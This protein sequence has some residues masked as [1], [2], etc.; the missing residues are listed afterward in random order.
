MPLS[1]VDNNTT[2]IDLYGEDANKVTIGNPDVSN[3]F[4]AHAKIEVFNGEDNIQVFEQDVKGSPILKDEKLNLDLVAKSIEWVKAGNTLK[5]VTTLKEKPLS[6]KIT[7]KLGGNWEDFNFHRQRP[8]AERYPGRPLEYF[9]RDG[10]DW[11]KVLFPDDMSAQRPV[12]VEGCYVAKHKTKRNHVLGKTN[13]RV[14]IAVAVL[15][16]KAVDAN[17][18]T[19][20]VDLLVKDGIITETIPQSF[21]DTAKYPVKVNVNYGLDSTA[22]TT[23]K[24]TTKL[25]VYAGGKGNPSQNGNLASI[26]TYCSQRSGSEN[27]T[28]GLFADSAGDAAALLE[29]TGSVAVTTVDWYSSNVDVEADAAVVTTSSYWLGQCTDSTGLNWYY[30]DLQSEVSQYESYPGYVAGTLTGFS[31]PTQWETDQE[32][33]IYAT[34]AA[35]GGVKVPVM[36]HHYKQAGGM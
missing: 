9:T 5:W 15:R 6:N 35:G 29:D 13:Y 32:F 36:V 1:K 12:D 21:L 33:C 2:Y 10:V 14:G 17:G 34:F 20:W 8:F 19:V 23:S 28:M 30:L 3:E 4:Q 25:Y 16:S 24:T 22:G 31:S 18:K 7:T 26:S 11:V 27:L